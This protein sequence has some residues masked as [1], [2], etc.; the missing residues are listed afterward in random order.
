MLSLAQWLETGGLGPSKHPKGGADIK[1][2]LLPGVQ[3]AFINHNNFQA[4]NQ[5]IFHI[6]VVRTGYW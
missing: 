1:H 5:I 2:N 6:Q 4:V 3:V